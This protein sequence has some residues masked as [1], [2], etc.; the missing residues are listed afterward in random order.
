M[1]FK[2]CFT[3]LQPQHFV[4]ESLARRPQ[5][6]LNTHQASSRKPPELLL[7]SLTHSTMLIF[8]HRFPLVKKLPTN[9]R[10]NPERTSTSFNR[11]QGASSFATTKNSTLSQTSISQ[12]RKA[13]S[14][15]KPPATRLKCHHLL[16]RQL[17]ENVLQ[18]PQCSS[19]MAGHH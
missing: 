12:K 2:H 3:R 5:Q 18:L 15:K 10:C 4:D 13:K 6:N 14:S 16:K 8:L 7:E 1:R 17:P 11:R 9:T 19:L